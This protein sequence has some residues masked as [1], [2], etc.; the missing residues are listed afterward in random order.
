LKTALFLHI[1][2]LF[3][4]IEGPDGGTPWW[5]YPGLELWKFVNL[6][7]FILCALYLH[8]RFGRPIK[9]GLRARS[10]AI[11]R[12]LKRAKEERDQA[13]GKLAEVEARFA[14]L[15]DEVSKVKERNAAEIE[16]ERE[17]IKST[18]EG[19]LARMRDQAKREIE[20]AGKAVRHELRRFAAQESIRMAEDI[21]KEEI[22]PEEHARL[23]NRSIEELRRPEL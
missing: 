21:L 13:L 6:L 11:K 12:E 7:L 15:D 14:R 10:E 4:M 16:A 2:N 1:F 8:R 17:R 22:G 20:S 5:N 18:T 19:E 3:A 9:E 23:T